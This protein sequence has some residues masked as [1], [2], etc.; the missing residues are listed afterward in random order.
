MSIADPEDFKAHDAASYDAVTERYD[1]YSVRVSIPFVERMLALAKIAPNERVL[2]VGTGTGIVALGVAIAFAPT[3]RVIGVDLSEAM[4]QI[5]KTK[6][7]E[8]DLDRST[9]FHHMDAETMTLGDASMDVVLSLF[10]LRH[11]PDPLAALREM[12]RVVRP[13]GRLVVAVGSGPQLFSL[14]GIQHGFRRLVGIYRERRG[15]QLRACDFLDSL[16]EQQLPD[17][18]GSEHAAWAGEHGHGVWSLPKLVRTTGFNAVHSEW[19]GHETVLDSAEE[20]W[21]L[22][23]T[24]SSL[25]RK[26]LAQASDQQVAELRSRFEEVCREVQGR[27]GRLIYPTGALFVT[28]T[29]A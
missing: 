20:F 11:F 16:V 12:Y 1:H 19:L 29:R 28:A 8:L 18:D 15:K 25:A 13:G 5:A 7:R 23:V 27:G 10:A 24:F 17:P 6:S 21:E 26:R 3:V 9:E 14:P 4:L 22:Q 2:D